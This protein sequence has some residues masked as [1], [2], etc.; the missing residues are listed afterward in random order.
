[1]VAIMDSVS[2]ANSSVWEQMADLLEEA[3]SLTLNDIRA[4]PGQPNGGSSEMS[5]V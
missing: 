5:G 3:A 1:M 2:M 4:N